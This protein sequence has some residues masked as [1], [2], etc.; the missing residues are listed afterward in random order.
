[1]HNLKL[2]YSL[3]IIFL[4]VV[5]PNCNREPGDNGPRY[6]ATPPAKKTQ[7]Y[8]FV[9]HP[10]HNPSKLVQTYQPL[11]D[12]LNSKLENAQ[13]LLEASRD[14]AA[15]E[16]KYKDQEPDF[17]LPNPWQTLQA[18][19][20]GYHVI[21][22]AGE[23]YDFK[24]I[25]IVR[26]N[27]KIKHPSELKG[28]TVCYPSRTALAACIMPQY[29]LYQNGININKDINNLY[30]GSQESSIM[31]VFVGK[32]VVGA[33]WPPPWRAFQREHPNE[34]AELKI[35]WETKPLINNSVMVRDDVPPEVQSRVRE[36]L[37]ALH[38]NAEGNK[39]LQGMETKYFIKAENKNYDIVKTYV[40]SFEKR[41]RKVEGK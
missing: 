36:L 24:G 1:M 37:I 17:L 5:V 28:K 30:V 26:K 38:E 9:V 21:A 3:L 19:K 7:T 2:L 18:I 8:S 29:F 11:I 41:V 35:I 10:L 23:S 39:I 27:T 6:I 34:A 40:N 33:T 16:K 22:I 14:Y 32:S 25:F 20:S 4:V 31:N 13:L 12:Y 15:F